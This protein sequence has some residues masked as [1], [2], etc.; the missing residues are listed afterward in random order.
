MGLDWWN[1]KS[2]FV[3]A[4]SNNAGPSFPPS[5]ETPRVQVNCLQLLPYFN[6]LMTVGSCQLWQVRKMW[7][8]RQVAVVMWQVAAADASTPIH[9]VRGFQG[10][11]LLRHDDMID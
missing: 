10:W 7:Q 4:R 9:I 5:I 1:I 8:V 11:L 3:R 2:K 6:S